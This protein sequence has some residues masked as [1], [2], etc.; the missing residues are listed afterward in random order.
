VRKCVSQ[1]RDNPR[2]YIV[3]SGCSLPTETPFANIDA[4][5]DAVREIGYPVKEFGPVDGNRP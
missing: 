5:M 3:A 4:M 1:A 2:G